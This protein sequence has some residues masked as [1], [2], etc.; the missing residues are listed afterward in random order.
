M[1]RDLQRYRAVLDLS[2]SQWALKGSC[3]YLRKHGDELTIPQIMLDIHDLGHIS[4]QLKR[5][6]VQPKHLSL[7]VLGGRWKNVW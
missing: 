3:L 4:T 2:S 5:L 1:V 7:L 6:S